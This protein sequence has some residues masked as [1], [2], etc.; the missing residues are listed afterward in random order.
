MF[1]NVSNRDCKFLSWFQ[2]FT[3]VKMP[4]IAIVLQ[5]VI[6]AIVVRMAEKEEDR[7]YK[8]KHKKKVILV[9]CIRQEK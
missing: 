8:I 7:I 6:N 2:P 1:Q 4:R 9:I 3:S 5:N